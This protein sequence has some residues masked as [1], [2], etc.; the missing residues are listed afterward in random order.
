MSDKIIKEENL[1][2]I[3]KNVVKDIKN[4]KEFS[5]QEIDK[6]MNESNENLEFIKVINDI[7]LEAPN[8]RVIFI[9]GNE[10]LLY[11]KGEFFICE[12]TDSRKPKKK[13]KRKEATEI[14]IEYFIR[15]QLNP[16]IEQKNMRSISQTIKKTEFIKEVQ[17]KSKALEDIPKIESK[18]TKSPPKKVIKSKD[19]L[20][21]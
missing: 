16:I 11:D 21:R 20:A 18:K 7:K 12:T 19:D 9:D 1:D 3:I 6:L 14:Y 10:Q 4:G 15:Y 2:E 5:S 13:I 8:N 17:A